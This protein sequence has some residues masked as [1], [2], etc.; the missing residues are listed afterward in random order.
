MR[1]GFTLV[2][3]I[4]ILVILGFLSI[5]AIEIFTKTQ[6]GVGSKAVKLS[7]LS[8]K[9]L[10]VDN[11]ENGQIPNDIANK[12]SLPSHTYTSGES[13]DSGQISLKWL[14]GNLVLL[15]SKETST[16][17]LYKLSLEGKEGWATSKDI[18]NAGN[19]TDS[20]IDGSEES[21]RVLN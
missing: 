18:C 15:A 5:G 20:S 7:L 2:E 4:V 8:T 19:Y 3:I 14:S 17:Y 6:S 13:V 16:C 12:I 9:E 1:K 10:I 21:P 11:L